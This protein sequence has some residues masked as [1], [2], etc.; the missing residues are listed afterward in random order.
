MLP[1]R[2]VI[3]D[4]LP[5]GHSGGSGRWVLCV[6]RFMGRLPV[7]LNLVAEQRDPDTA[8]RFTN[9][10][11]QSRGPMGIDYRGNSPGHRADGDFLFDRAAPIGVR[12]YRRCGQVATSVLLFGTTKI[13]ST[14][15]FEGGF[16][17]AISILPLSESK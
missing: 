6:C 4:P 2:C 8:D 3:S 12:S 15:D 10:H 17:D 9:I 7:R 5:G 11:E 13:E 14:P 16:S 1:T